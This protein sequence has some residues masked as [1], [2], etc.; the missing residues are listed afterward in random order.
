MDDAEEIEDQFSDL[1]SDQKQQ[2]AELFKKLY[3]EKVEEEVSR[4]FE[5]DFQIHKWYV[6]QTTTEYLEKRNAAES[7]RSSSATLFEKSILQFSVGAIALS[8][9]FLQV[10]EEAPIYDGLLIA[11]W[12]AFGFSIL[13]M[14]GNAISTQYAMRS[15]I[16]IYDNQFRSARKTGLDKPVLD[17]DETKYENWASRSNFA[18]WA[19]GISFLAGIA[20]FA[21]FTF[22][23]LPGVTTDQDSLS[24]GA[25]NPPAEV[26]EAQPEISSD[27][28]GT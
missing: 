4:Y 28:S 1:D 14:L 23:N 3:E 7:L 20:L 5:E 24:P 2:V 13:A 18:Y 22:L 12:V 6:E 21:A 10:L 16:N 11:S 25:S 26:Q 9:T 27:T 19:S 17:F 8:L 15:Q